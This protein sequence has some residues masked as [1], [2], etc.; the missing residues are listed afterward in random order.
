MY[1]VNKQKCA[2]CQV[3]VASCP[4]AIKIGSDGKAEVVDQEKLESCGGTSVC[5]MG[6]IEVVK[7]S[8]KK[9]K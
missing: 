2:G 1:R 5:P 4:G 9:N 7:E 3:C 8:G 6:A